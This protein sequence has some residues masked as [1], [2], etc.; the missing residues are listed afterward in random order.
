M[1]PQAHELQVK[2]MHGQVT[3]P[4]NEPAL[5]MPVVEDSG[6]AMLNDAPCAGKKRSTRQS[7]QRLEKEIVQAVLLAGSGDFLGRLCSCSNSSGGRMK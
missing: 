7:C 1:T 3:P 5:T 2:I 6:V 4:A